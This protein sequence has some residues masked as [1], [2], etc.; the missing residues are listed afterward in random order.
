MAGRFPGA[1]SV[2]ALWQALCEGRDGIT[3][4]SADTLDP[5][6]PASLR[7]DPAY[8]PAR[9]VFDGYDRVDAAFFGIAPKEAELMD[10]QQRVFLELG[11]EGIDHAGDVAAASTG[12]VGEVA[13][14]Y[15][16]SHS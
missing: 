14:M 4:F 6:I 15:N 7:A 12:P 10:P 16:P 2:E 3:R 11:W 5:P 13:G 8:V 9:G 1:A